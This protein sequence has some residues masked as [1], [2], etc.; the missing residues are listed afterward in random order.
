LQAAIERKNKREEK[1][2]EIS[3]RLKA[4]QTKR[5]QAYEKA[6]EEVCNLT[7]SRWSVAQLK[8]L[9]NY[10]KG[11]R[12]NGLNQRLVLNCWRNGRR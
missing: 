1:E 4:E 5:K 7:P 3:E 12:I 11:R 8:A 2:K 6:L 10:K 9:V